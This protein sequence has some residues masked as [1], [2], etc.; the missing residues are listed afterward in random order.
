MLT[1]RAGTCDATLA[2]MAG[3]DVIILFGGSSSE[4]RVSVASGQHVSAVL[5][6]AEAWFLAPSGAVHRVPRDVFAGFEKPFERDF[7]PPGPAAFASVVEGFESHAAR[8]FFL[9]LHGGEG[10]DGTIQRM[11]EA[12]RIAF[13]GP[14]A[15][16]S[17]R[18]FDKE[19]AKQVAGAAGVR[20]AR[21][22]HLSK[23]PR[24]LRQELQEMLAIYG[25]VVAKPVAGGSSVGLYHLATPDE[26]DRAADGIDESGEPYLAEEF[27]AGTEL[28][29]GVVDGP[30]GARA[31]P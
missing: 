25:R 31:L 27:V 1:L 8:V 7:E 4:R 21:S 23:D 30:S 22:V 14:G 10:E 24:K 26:A 5:D 6:E 20:T 18:A 2:A 13:T 9:A 28:T 29:V 12:R 17:A 16:A 15:E 3:S 11:L 19:V